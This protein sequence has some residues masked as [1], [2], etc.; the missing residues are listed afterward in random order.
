MGARQVHL[1]L[2]ESCSGHVGDCTGSDPIGPACMQLPFRPKAIE[3]LY[4]A[5][6]C[7]KNGMIDL[8]V[9]MLLSLLS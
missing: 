8:I 6:D 5:E 7:K 9:W 4:V 2:S 3:I 1:R